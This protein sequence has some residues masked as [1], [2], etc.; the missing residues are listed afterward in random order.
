MK[1]ESPTARNLSLEPFWT[2]LTANRK[3]NQASRL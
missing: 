2:S 1:L 3:F